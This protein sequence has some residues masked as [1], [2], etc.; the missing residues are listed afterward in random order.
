LI[1]KPS[2]FVVGFAGVPGGKAR[3][4]FS[5]IAA[6]HDRSIIQ[7]AI[8]YDVKLAPIGVS[9]ISIRPLLLDKPPTNSHFLRLALSL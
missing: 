2:Q 1:C 7:M 8:H 5:R 3:S 4:L 6:A 9:A